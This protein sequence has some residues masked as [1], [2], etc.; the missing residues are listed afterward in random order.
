M[1]VKISY[2]IKKECIINVTPEEYFNLR[3]NLS[4]SQYFPKE[5]YDR[6]IDITDDAENELWNYWDMKRKEMKND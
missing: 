6:D 4:N 2:T 3:A 1:E 5:A